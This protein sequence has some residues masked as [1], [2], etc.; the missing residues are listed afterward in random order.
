MTT[1]HDAEDPREKYK[2]LPPP[3]R[4]DDTVTSQETWPAR[5]PEGGRNTDR[6]F[7]IRN[8]GS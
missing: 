4:V 1:E 2:Q 8:A 7:E 3:V 5:D 6:D